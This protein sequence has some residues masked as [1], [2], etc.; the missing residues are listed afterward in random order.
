MCK[1]SLIVNTKVFFSGISRRAGEG[2]YS[3]WV[4]SYCKDSSPKQQPSNSS[5]QNIPTLALAR[6]IL[7][8][9]IGSRAQIFVSLRSAIEDSFVVGS[10]EPQ[11]PEVLSIAIASPCSHI[12]MGPYCS[13]V[14][15]TPDVSA[16]AGSLSEMQNPSPSPSPSPLNQ[17][18]PLTEN[19]QVI[20]MHIEH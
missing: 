19:L 12:I 4:A 11:K 15:C 16:S 5:A 6:E 20:P 9:E 2:A 8:E 1:I 13:K 10:W 17:D 3:Q 18:L 14:A 7:T